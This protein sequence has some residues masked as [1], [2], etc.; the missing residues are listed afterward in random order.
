MGN[1][2]VTVE[3]VESRTVL[4]RF[5]DVPYLLHR[6]DPRWSPGVRAYESWRIDARR[7]PYFEQ[8][9]AAYFLARRSGQPVGRIAAHRDRPRTPDGRFGLFDVPDDDEVTRALLGAAAVWL[10]EEGATTMTGPITWTPDEEFGVPVA[11]ADQPGLTGRRWQPAWY[12]EQLRAAGLR[13]A[14]SRHSYRLA[15]TVPGTPVESSRTTA[16]ARTDMAVAAPAG[17]YADP[18]L[19]LDGIAAVPDVS[20][21]L[22][23][24]SLRSAWKVARRA[25]HRRFDVAVCVHCDGPP[26]LLVPRLQAAAGDAGYR[27][28]V[29]PWAPAGTTPETTHQVFTQEL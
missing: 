12:G 29:A 9:D 5:A 19:V 28:V 27:W 6:H 1:G 21:V 26:E 23:D 2:P 15:T 13:E 14:E 16:R 25:R 4:R 8:G 11:G 10:G 20:G 24:A 22:A 17:R 7:H 3:P 18:A